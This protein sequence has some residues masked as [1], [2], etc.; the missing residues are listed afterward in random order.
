MLAGLLHPK[1]TTATVLACWHAAARLHRGCPLAGLSKLVESD[2]LAR[3]ERRRW[4]LSVL[5][6]SGARLRLATSSR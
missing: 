6:D 5:M 2:T 4:A 1:I 3:R